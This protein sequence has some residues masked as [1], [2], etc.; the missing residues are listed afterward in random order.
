MDITY[1]VGPRILNDGTNLDLDIL[2][3]FPVEEIEQSIADPVTSL[4]GL[5]YEPGQ[6][7]KDQTPL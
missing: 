7:N 1:S 5:G 4:T 3:S 6:L 2:A